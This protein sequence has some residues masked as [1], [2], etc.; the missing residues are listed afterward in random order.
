MGS[1][2]NKDAPL[3]KVTPR[4]LATR[5]EAS[6]ALKFF[7]SIRTCTKVVSGLITVDP[8]GAFNGVV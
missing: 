3:G 4:F 6:T 2:D 7:V 1:Y 5:L 8:T